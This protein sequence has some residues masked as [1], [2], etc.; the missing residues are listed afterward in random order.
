MR[1]NQKKKSLLIPALI[2][3]LLICIVGNVV[4]LIIANNV[5][6]SINDNTSRVKK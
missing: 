5:G 6:S 1:K 4:Q 2:A 3:A